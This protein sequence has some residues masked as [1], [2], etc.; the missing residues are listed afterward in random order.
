MSATATSRVTCLL[1]E[2]HPD[3]RPSLRERDVLLLERLSHGLTDQMI[4][5]EIHLSAETVRANIRGVVRALGA[6]NRAHAVA[7][8]LKTGVIR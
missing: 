1:I 2:E 3:R 4:A 8:A 7:I 5:E 6:R